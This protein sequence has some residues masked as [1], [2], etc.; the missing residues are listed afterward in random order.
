M[1][2]YPCKFRGDKVGTFNCGCGL[3]DQ[4][5]FKCENSALG[6]QKCVVRLGN[7]KHRPQARGL[8]SCSNCDFREYDKPIPSR[9]TRQPRPPSPGRSNFVRQ[10]DSF[11]AEQIRKREIS[12]NSCRALPGQDLIVECDD[13][14]YGDAVIMSWIAEGS[15]NSGTP[16]LLHA[17]GDKAN[18]LAILGQQSHEG[19]R[20]SQRCFVRPEHASGYSHPRL[21]FRAQTIGVTAMPKRPPI[22]LPD[23]ARQWAREAIG[24]SVLLA[25]QSAHIDREWAASRWLELAAL[26]DK[27]GIPFLFTGVA[28]RKT[29]GRWPGIYGIKPFNRACALIAEAKSVIAIDS[30]IANLAGTANVPTVC[31]LSFTTPQ[32]FSHTP[33][34]KCIRR[35]D[36]NIHAIS[37][38][39]VF[40]TY[41]EMMN[42]Q[43]TSP[44]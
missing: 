16:C 35:D 10:G 4:D 19:R 30:F 14:G 1:Y 8:A 11:R 32:V 2:D 21:E 31:I 37:P 29:F 33:S 27:E 36:Q 38:Y 12:R 23:E 13:Y 6:N 20:I 3:G 25:P 28:P 34:V 15:K 17:T 44:Q 43:P 39:Q 7:T 42:V 24:D 26:L 9:P 18:L 5:V 40:Q 41:K 22:I